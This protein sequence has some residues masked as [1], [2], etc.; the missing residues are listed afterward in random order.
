VSVTVFVLRTNI[1]IIG[2]LVKLSYRCEKA[3]HCSE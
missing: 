2:F 3:L 1:Q